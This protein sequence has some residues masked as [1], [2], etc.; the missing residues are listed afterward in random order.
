MFN[1]LRK[2]CLSNTYIALH[3]HQQ[4]VV[5]PIS[6]LSSQCLVLDFQILA[7][8]NG[9]VSLLH[10]DFNFIFAYSVSECPNFIVLHVAIQHL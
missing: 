8:L 7:N 4:Y 6:I 2:Y 1:I 9:C 10:Y 5:V 3:P